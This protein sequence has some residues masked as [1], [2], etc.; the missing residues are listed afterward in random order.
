VSK[1]GNKLG[2]ASPHNAYPLELTPPRCGRF[3][4][5]APAS[6]RLDK[7]LTRREIVAGCS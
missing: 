5:N 4:L 1:S 2:D 6:T 7:E 3:P